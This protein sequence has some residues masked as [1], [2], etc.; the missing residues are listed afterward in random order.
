MPTIQQR[1]CPGL[2]AL[3]KPSERLRTAQLN[4]VVNVRMGE[5][6]IEDG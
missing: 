5:I 4:S 3:S 2:S 1:L 6:D